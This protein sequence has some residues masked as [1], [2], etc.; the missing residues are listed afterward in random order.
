MTG[1]VLYDG[2]GETFAADYYFLG[3]QTFTSSSIF[4]GS[5]SNTDVFAAFS[6]PRSGRNH[7]GYV[8]YPVEAAKDGYIISSWFNYTHQRS[9]MQYPAVTAME[10]RMTSSLSWRDSRPFKT[11]Q[12]ALQFYPT[13]EGTEL[14]NA[15]ASS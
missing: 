2:N 5:Q 11:I 12:D 13:D 9:W 8:A 6:M 4:W 3:P 7:R 15:S 1:R 10:K 14:I